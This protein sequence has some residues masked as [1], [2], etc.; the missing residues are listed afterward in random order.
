PAVVDDVG[1]VANGAYVINYGGPPNL[2]PA[3]AEAA[4]LAQAFK[5]V[6]LISDATMFKGRRRGNIVMVGTQTPLANPDLG[7]E[8]AFLAALRAE[9]LPDQAKS[10]T[11]TTNFIAG[12][13]PSLTPLLYQEPL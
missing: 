5:H 7:G 4:A 1:T 10:G 11:E 6:T 13:P 8:D 12:T 9:P 3:R 2:T